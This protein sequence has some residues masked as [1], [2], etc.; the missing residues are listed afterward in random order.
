MSYVDVFQLVKG[1]TFNQ[2]EIKGKQETD[3][4]DINT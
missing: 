4:K 2:R 3:K 1:N